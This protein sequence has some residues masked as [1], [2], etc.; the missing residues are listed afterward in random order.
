MFALLKQ[1]E[2]DFV[3][4]NMETY[5]SLVLGLSERKLIYQEIEEMNLPPRDDGSE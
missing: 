1:E 4:D 2:G 5:R 3:I